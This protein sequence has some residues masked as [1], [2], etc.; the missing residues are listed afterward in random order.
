[1]DILVE[2]QEALGL[3]GAIVLD[4]VDGRAF[5]IDSNSLRQVK[6]AV[7]G[8]TI[9]ECGDIIRAG[10]LGIDLGRVDRESAATTRRIYAAERDL[11][12]AFDGQIAACPQGRIH[13]RS[14]LD[15]TAVNR[16]ISFG[17]QAGEEALGNHIG[18]RDAQV[19]TRGT[20][21]GTDERGVAIVF[22][23]QDVNHAAVFDSEV[24]GVNAR[25]QRMRREICVID[26]YRAVA[27][28][29]NATRG[30]NVKGRRACRNVTD[31]TYAVPRFPCNIDREAA[32]PRELDA[33]C[34]HN[35]QAIIDGNVVF[36]LK[37]DVQ[38]AR[39]F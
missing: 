11:C 38:I 15:G 34:S 28:D 26:E 10:V 5:A 7:D 9:K 19:T 2:M 23:R 20:A 29:A 4:E 22:R 6:I 27:G 21:A 1:M 16:Q 37:Y 3:F 12:A 31:G 39:Q 18:V 17:E 33:P 8:G 30:I 36:A 13:G 25:I 14:R 32:R 24:N 35:T